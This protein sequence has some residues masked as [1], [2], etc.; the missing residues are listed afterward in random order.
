[1]DQ[2]LT[3]RGDFILVKELN[4][5]QKIAGTNLT[6]KFDDN[7][8]FMLAEIVDVSD[9]LA[10]EYAKYYPA[11]KNIMDAKAVTK[12]FKPGTKVVLQRI[13]KVPYKDGLY[14]ASFK[15]IL[16]FID[17]DEPLKETGFKQIT[18]FEREE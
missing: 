9:E 4:E 13:A 17:L 14:F 12:K 16:A 7:S 10:L 6:M 8:H 18:L 2:K 15:D 3:L 11:I 5:D 1:M